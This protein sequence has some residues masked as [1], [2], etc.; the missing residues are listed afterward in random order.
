[1]EQRHTLPQVCEFFPGKLISRSGDIN[2]FPR[3]PDLTPMDFFLWSYVKYKVYASKLT[4]LEHL[5][6]NI[7]R[8][9]AVIMESIS[10]E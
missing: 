2:W 7:P 4:L 10:A 9:M 3:S 8:E 1:M 6:E 5:T